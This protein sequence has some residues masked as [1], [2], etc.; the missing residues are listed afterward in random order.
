MDREGE[1]AQPRGMSDSSARPAF[2]EFFAGGGMVRAGL[3][4]GWRCLFANDIDRRKAAAYRANWG[5][6]DFHAGDIADIRTQDLPEIPDLVWGSF[7]CQ[8]LSLAGGGAGLEGRRSGTFHAFFGLVTDLAAEGRAPRLVVIENV[9]GALTSRGGRDFAVICRTFLDAGYRPGALVINA[10]RFVPQSRPRLFVVGVREDLPVPPTLV[11]GAPC[12]PFH[13]TALVRAADRLAPDLRS[14]LVWWRVPKPTAAPPALADVIESEPP[15][16]R[17][18][19]AA[20]TRRLLDL[21]APLHRARVTAAGAGG[22]RVVGTVFR[23][24]RTEG[25][26]RVQRAEIRFDRAGCLRTPAGGSSRQ[27]VVVIDGR[28][29]RSRLLTAREAARLMGLDD[30]YRL[31]ATF[32]AAIHLAGD[33]VAVPVVRHLAEFLFEPLVAKGASSLRAA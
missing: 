22:E 26:R 20:Q 30:N 21:M 17:W 14:R 23:R 15:G 18:H 19:S 12:D 24:T 16:A 9:C 10:D 29:V 8:D 25:G 3:G 13:T 6:A 4:D 28:R 2:Y 1:G 5:E 27:I 33:G 11:T 31:P 32:G 7:P